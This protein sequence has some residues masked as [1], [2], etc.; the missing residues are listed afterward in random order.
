MT[1]YRH[2][3]TNRLARPVLLTLL[4]SLLPGSPAAATPAAQEVEAGAD[5]VRMTGRVVAAQ[6]GEGVPGV[7]IRLFGWPD[8]H[9][10][11]A[12]GR[13][14]FDVPAGR[15][16]LSAW[17]QGYVTVKSTLPAETP[18]G[19]TLVMHRLPAVD[20]SVPG[21]LVVRVGESESGRPVEGA[22]VLLAGVGVRVTDTLGLAEFRDL[23][24]SMAE[25]TVEMIGYRKEAAEVSLRLERT[26]MIQ[27]AMT[28]EAIGLEP[29]EVEARSRFL[30]ARGVYWRIDHGRV[31]HLLTREHLDT[32]SS[33]SDAL[34]RLPG[35]RAEYHGGLPYVIGRR[36]CPVRMFLDG[37]P[38]VIDNFDD[39]SPQEVEVVE[40]FLAERTPAQ[41]GGINNKCGSVVMWSRRKAGRGSDR[42]R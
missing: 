4:A 38:L 39:L 7:V 33:L 10:T 42:G 22:A 36:R 17:K 20:L 9:V 18:G 41:F 19:F 30:E 24:D 8:R 16:S 11:G 40:V 23:D 12:D 25:V 31:Q 26:T 35:M 37:F 15:Y 28:A 5:V 32:L 21:R 27:M 14:S 6:G 34:D 29:L 13:L 3:L 1:D 2:N